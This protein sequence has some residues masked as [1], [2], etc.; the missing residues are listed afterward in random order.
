[1]VG[2]YFVAPPGEAGVSKVVS[3]VLSAAI[4]AMEIFITCPFSS[5]GGSAWSDEGEAVVRGPG[6]VEAFEAELTPPRVAPEADHIPAAKEAEPR[7]VEEDHGSLDLYVGVFDAEV[8]SVFIGRALETTLRRGG[9]GFSGG[10]RLIESKERDLAHPLVSEASRGKV[11]GGD[12]RVRVSIVAGRHQLLRGS[13]VAR[14]HAI[15]GRGPPGY[16]PRKRCWMSGSARS[17][18]GVPSNWMRPWSMT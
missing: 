5:G 1:M 16:T 12:A 11:V 9:G 7:I 3:W 6:L 15:H 2:G 8:Q 17:S 18:S 10:G 14:R 4:F 13:T